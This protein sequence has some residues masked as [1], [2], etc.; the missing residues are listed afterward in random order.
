MNSIF[1]EINEEKVKKYIRKDKPEY[2]FVF[3]LLLECG[4][5]LDTIFKLTIDDVIMRNN[6][7]FISVTT[8]DRK[9]EYSV[10]AEIEESFLD[11]VHRRENLAGKS[12]RY[13]FCT[14]TGNRTHQSRFSVYLTSVGKKL[15]I[16]D[17]NSRNLKKIYLDRLDLQIRGNNSNTNYDNADYQFVVKSMADYCNTSFDIYVSINEDKIN[18]EKLDRIRKMYV[19]HIYELEQ[20]LELLKRA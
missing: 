4:L 2:Y 6:E 5:N 7:V 11:F 12:S 13:L 17:L 15:G 9:K 19:R 3:V 20:V 18:G 1:D 14:A 8:H 16:D 10:P